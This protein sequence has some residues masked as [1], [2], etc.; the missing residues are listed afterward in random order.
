MEKQVK[1][2]TKYTPP[3]KNAKQYPSPNR[4]EGKNKDNIISTQVVF[5]L[6][7]FQWCVQIWT[8]C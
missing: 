1:C 3:S 5:K 6:L 8:V 4:H 7:I 2:S